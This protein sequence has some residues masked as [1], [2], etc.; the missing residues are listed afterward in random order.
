MI[1]ILPHRTHLLAVLLLAAAC[2]RNPVTGKSE[3][4]L[5]SEDQ[6]IAMGKQTRD[7]T[8]RTYGEFQNPEARSLVQRIGMD[9][10]KASERPNLPWEFHVIDDDQVNAFAAPG[11]FIFVTRGILTHMN[12]EAELASVLGHEIGHVTA[13]HTAS[14][15]TKAELAQLGLGVGMIFSPTVRSMG[16]ALSQGLQVLFLKFGR[17]AEAM[18]D[19]L[20][21]RYMVADGYDP[22]G[23][24]EMFRTLERVSARSG[25]T[26][27]EWASTHPDP[28]NRIAAAAHRIDSLQK[29]GRDPSKLKDNGPQFVRLLDGMTYGRDPRQ[30][31]FRG[32]TFYHP[33]LRFQFTFPQGWKTANLP[34]QVVAQSPQGDAALRLQVGQGSPEQAA[35]Q[36]FQQQG[37]RAGA[38]SRGS[39]NGFETVAGDF[40]AQ[41]Q[42]GTPVTGSAAFLAYGGRTYALIG[43]A[44]SGRGDVSGAFRQVLNTFKPLTDPA[45]LSVRAATV[46]TVRVPRDMTVQQFNAQFPSTI[47]VEELALIN[48]VDGP[49]STLAAGRLAKQ[50]TGGSG[51]QQTARDNGTGSR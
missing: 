6:E 34:D 33:D 49:S 2:A 35:Q 45:M 38:V 46:H 32:A 14:Q 47:P 42:D 37:L 15:V 23:A 39:V 18:A 28:G 48:G 10:A 1:A 31:F 22:N 12:S 30:G 24:E 17:D 51:D 27:P 8:L 7:E 43:M 3:L 20:G 4:S 44:A 13:R 11:G 21:F 5:V 40:T 19:A 36:F 26:L 29:A 25:Q 9:I 50:V 41:A 16:G